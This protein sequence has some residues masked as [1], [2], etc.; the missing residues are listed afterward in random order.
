M[1]SRVSE[2]RFVERN[3]REVGE[4]I[5]CV[6]M[7]MTFSQKFDT[8]KKEAKMLRRAEKMVKKCCRKVRRGQQNRYLILFGHGK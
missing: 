2:S 4:L 3:V 1:F 6:F 7:S 5:R 8:L